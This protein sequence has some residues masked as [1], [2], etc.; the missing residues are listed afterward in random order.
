MQNVTTP[1][2]TRRYVSLNIGSW[3]TS[4]KTRSGRVRCLPICNDKPHN[5]KAKLTNPDPHPLTSFSLHHYPIHITLSL[6]RQRKYPSH[7][8]PHPILLVPSQPILIAATPIH[9]FTI[10]TYVSYP[11]PSRRA[12]AYEYWESW[13]SVHRCRLVVYDQKPVSQLLQEVVIT[14]PFL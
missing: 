7:P 5:F 6:S 3:F 13:Y 1:M 10:P 9:Q 11:T 2:R 12:F 4:Q 14:L 8:H